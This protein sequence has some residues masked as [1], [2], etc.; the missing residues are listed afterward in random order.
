ML[1][2]RPAG[3]LERLDDGEEPEQ[4]FGVGEREL[5]LRQAKP[6]PIVR[7]PNRIDALVDVGLCKL[8]YHKRINEMS[9]R[10]SN[11]VLLGRFLKLIGEFKDILDVNRSIWKSYCTTRDLFR[12]SS[13]QLFVET[14]IARIV[15]TCFLCS[16]VVQ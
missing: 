15:K 6:L 3:D 12:L 4:I 8:C 7:A 13:R 1:K 16:A 2:F 10:G 5:D 14:M 9:C 11:E